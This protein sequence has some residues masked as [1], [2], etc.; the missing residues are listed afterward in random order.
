LSLRSLLAAPRR[1]VARA[2]GTEL[3]G[4]AKDTVWVGAWQSVGTVVEFGIIALLTHSLG[5]AE[6]GRYTVVLATVAL[7]GEFFSF[8]VA[9]ATT[10]YAADKLGRDDRAA[11]GVVQLSFL[12]E[13]AG[14]TAAVIL[15]AALA[16]F[17][18]PELIGADGTLML[19]AFAF[20]L[21]T[22]AVE[23]PCLALLRLLD[24][25]RLITGFTAIV[26]ITRFALA[27]AAVLIFDSLLA[28]I[29]AIAIAR[30]VAGVVTAAVASTVFRRFSDGVRL[31]EPAVSHVTR[32]DRRGML[33]TILHTNVI[34]YSK[35]VQ[36]QLPTVLLAAMLG[37]VQTAVYKIGTA[38]SAI[39]GKL[40]DTATPALLPRLSKLWAAGR[41]PELRRLIEQASLI[42]IPVTLLGGALL[43]YFRDPILEAI[44]T[45]GAAEAAGTVFILGV[46]GQML[47]VASFWRS[48]VL[49]A[50]R[51]A[52]AVSA[53]AVCSAAVQLAAFLALVP[54]IGVNGAAIAL[55][56]NRVVSMAV[57]T[58]VAIRTLRAAESTAPRA[59]RAQPRPAAS[60]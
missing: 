50:A 24:R 43:I 54:A 49:F 11:A 25:F 2:R 17:I 59:P 31:T 29:V 58:T 37:P 35:L 44:G 46:V 36:M 30:L 34:A 38:A 9:I 19:I 48:T 53:T 42:T 8:R 45:E 16:P 3:G 23:R 7:I 52:S 13:G 14:A 39:L 56:L 41:Q 32:S 47:Y 60:G 22:G 15:L 12:A 28:V 33:K 57:L 18:G 6:Y 1:L 27:L 5:L 51:R 26:E 10:T 40:V 55:L 21:L 20:T 4:L